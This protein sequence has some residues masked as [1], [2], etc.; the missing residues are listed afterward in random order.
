MKKLTLGLLAAVLAISACGVDGSQQ[1]ELPDNPNTAVLQVRSDG[2]FAPVEWILSRGPRFTLL[3][4]GRLIHEGP[5]ITIYPGP[6][7]PN[8]Q[9]VT[10]TDDQMASVLSLVQEIGLPDMADEKDDTNAQTVAD[11]TTEVVTYWDEAGSH[12]YS[13]YALGLVPNPTSRSTA[14]FAE[15]LNLLDE[16][17]FQGD[18]APYEA[19]RVQVI[20]GFGFVDPDFQNVRD[21]PLDNTDVEDWTEFPNG[22]TCK[23]FGPEMLD[24]FT[25]ANQATQWSNPV[26]DPLTLLV[27]PLH[28]GEEPCFGN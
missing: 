12:T 25:D 10:I 17:S 18:A 24:S 20:A 22:W 26:G 2:G 23:V 14:A 11:A 6:L 21:W 8:Y 28:P 4:D 27:R 15:L 7:L 1:I 3:A 19:E 13:V 16:L 9:V 5:T